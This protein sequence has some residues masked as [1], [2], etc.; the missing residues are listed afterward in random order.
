MYGFINIP[1]G[2]GASDTYSH[3]VLS[4]WQTFETGNTK[5]TKA[6]TIRIAVPTI[7]S[8]A[9]V[10]IRIGNFFIP[11]DILTSFTIL[12]LGSRNLAQIYGGKV[13]GIA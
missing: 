3:S 9:P 4:E 1:S 8:E 11:I 10:F 6:N 12:H 7:E 5:R 2:E 13:V